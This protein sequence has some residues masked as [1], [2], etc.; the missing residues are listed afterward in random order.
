MPCNHCMQVYSIVEIMENSL[1]SV[2]ESLNMFSIPEL[3]SQPT[4]F[5][6]YD[7]SLLSKTL[8]A[9][10][11]A[12][13]AY[14]FHVH[15]ALKAN[16]ND[17]V[18]DSIHAA[19]LGADCVS[20]NEVRKAVER[21][22]L[23]SSIVFAGVGKSDWE[24]EEA[25]D[26]DILAFNCESL[27]E[28]EV[29]N[30]LAGRK[31]K[32]ARVAIRINPNIN[33]NTHHY[34]TTGLNENKFG[35]NSSDLDE[36]VTLLRKSEHLSFLGLHFHVGSQITDMEV[37]KNLCIRVNELT[38]WFESR[39][40]PVRVLNVGG[41]LGIDYHEPVLNPVPDFESYFSIFNQYLHRRPDQQVHFELGRSIVGQCGN[42]IS[43][44]L[45]IKKGITINFAIIDAGLTELIRPALYQAWHQ[46]ENITPGKENSPSDTY[47]VVGPICESS[48]VFRKGVE[49]PETFR[50]DL[51]L[52]RSAGAYGQVMSS[53]YNLRNLA[54]AVYAY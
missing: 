29:L 37:F 10:T 15:Y 47:D 6:F 32:I 44:V 28:L 39:N 46:I 11:E 4:P 5:Y 48:D 20:G 53:G 12:S 41:G 33:A 42:L 36:V 40:L 3:G 13:S 1:K 2:E 14:G 18:L 24:M 26:L 49:M 38:A 17:P 43:K 51:I 30:E 35:V 9:C 7:M 27:Q 21:G 50:G 16:F 52:I 31:K 54:E 45:F 34:I 23:P 19:G 22:F 25:L 8:K